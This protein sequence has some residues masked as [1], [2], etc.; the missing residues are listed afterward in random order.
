MFESYITI[1]GK[2]VESFLE[3]CKNITQD[4]E[5]LEEC[6]FPHKEIVKE[7]IEI[8]AEAEPRPYRNGMWRLYTDDLHVNALVYGIVVNLYDNIF[9][10]KEHEN[11]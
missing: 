1:K 5:L 8:L 10:T 9:N 2:N 3:M 6:N 4:K 11:V 7:Q